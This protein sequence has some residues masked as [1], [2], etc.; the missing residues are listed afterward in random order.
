MS[1]SPPPLA[2][3]GTGSGWSSPEPEPRLAGSGGVMPG[4]YPPPLVEGMA[5][6]RSS[7]GPEMKEV[8]GPGEGGG[9]GTGE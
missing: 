6:V 9:F 8:R 3:L 2:E 4:H 5:E 7:R 1:I